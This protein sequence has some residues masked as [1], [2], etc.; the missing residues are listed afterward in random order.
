MIAVVLVLARSASAEGPTPA[1]AARLLAGG[2][3]DAAAGVAA[4]EVL[5]SA[6]TKEERDR[7]VPP[8]LDALA[9][10]SSDVRAAAALAL[11]KIRDERALGRLSKRMAE[12]S[13]EAVLASLLLAVGA[14]G[15]EAEVP[16]VAPYA[17]RASARLRCAA[18]TALGDLGGPAARERL[19]ALLLGPGEDPEWAVRGA[20]FL[21]LARG[22][23]RED[24]GTIFVA[25]RDGRGASS[26]FARASLARSIALLDVDPVPTLDR[27]VA[28]D[29]G[30]V[31]AAAAA[32]FV[33]AKKPEEAVKRLD[34]RRPGV[35]AACAVALAEAR[36]EG[37]TAKIL[38]MATG[39]ES[40][41]VRWSAALALSRL[42]VAEADGLVLEGLAS[43]D[44]AVWV[45]ALAEL[46]RK[47]GRHVGR[48]GPA[49]KRVLSERRAA[50]SK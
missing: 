38:A 8:L 24:A 26:W 16:L 7:A 20:V 6:T 17:N 25:Y 44:A 11:A 33:L 34:D 13:D 5:A 22:G 31:S 12:E 41:A 43:D 9:H 27:L 36:V 28:D 3:G 4:A 42:D 15:G 46:E 29:D 39:D 19:L 47:T 37:V 48:D 23:V 18:A 32:G 14:V 35:R 21:A 40:R 50:L 49:W 2:G 45:T 1:E 30:R 10:R